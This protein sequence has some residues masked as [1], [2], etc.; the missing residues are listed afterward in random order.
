MDPLRKAPLLLCIAVLVSAT[1]VFIATHAACQIVNHKGT[2]NIEDIVI[3]MRKQR[4]MIVQNSNQLRAIYAALL[5][6]IRNP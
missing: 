2:P 5:H 1:G 3:Q 6:S 4:G